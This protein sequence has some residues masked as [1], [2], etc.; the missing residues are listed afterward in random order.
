MVVV[1]VATSIPFLIQMANDTCPPKHKLMAT[2]SVKCT[3][4]LS[5]PNLCGHDKI[6]VRVK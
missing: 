2:F 1:V 4:T 6:V 5:V 3:S